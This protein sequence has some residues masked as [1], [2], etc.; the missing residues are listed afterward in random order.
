M[1]CIS[2]RVPEVHC[3]VAK[4]NQRDNMQDRH[5]VAQLELPGK[6]KIDL[7]AVFDGHDGHHA[8]EE[9][10]KILPEM[11]AD[12]LDKLDNIH[13]P[14]AVTDALYQTVLAV[15]HKMYQGGGFSSGSTGVIAL[16]PHNDNYLY[17]ANVGDSRA[18]VWTEDKLI[19]ETQDHKPEHEVERITASGGF[20]DN[21]L[22]GGVL[23][24]S[25][26]FGDFRENLKLLNRRYM[27]VRA[28]V[29]PEPDVYRVDLRS[30]PGKVRMVLASDGLWDVMDTIDVIQFFNVSNDQEQCKSIIAEAIRRG[31]GDN[32]TVMVIDIPSCQ[33]ASMLNY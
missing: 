30:H 18:I 13:A 12:K 11:L 10:L 6:G 15:D 2:K 7:V 5:L 28:P 33:K 22:V 4:K 9:L 26:S 14:L 23:G 16:W 24:V 27:G 3:Q 31:S 20:T 1:D 21:G 25:R 8:A 17:I 29:S 32:I 19:I